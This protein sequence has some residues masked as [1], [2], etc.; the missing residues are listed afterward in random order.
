MDSRVFRRC[1]VRGVGMWRVVSW[2][3]RWLERLGQGIFVGV[4]FMFRAEV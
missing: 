2:V 3:W 4:G 1:R